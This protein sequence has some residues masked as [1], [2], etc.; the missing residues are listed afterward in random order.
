MLAQGFLPALTSTH[1]EYQHAIRFGDRVLGRIWF[2]GFR[3]QRWHFGFEI[4]ANDQIA[5]KARQ[6][7]ILINLADA[8]IR[9]IPEDMT[10]RFRPERCP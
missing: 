5:A 8:N 10:E 3:G 6:T 2:E 9:S 7:G 4:V 1:I